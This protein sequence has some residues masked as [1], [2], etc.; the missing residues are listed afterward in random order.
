MKRSIQ[1]ELMDDEGLD[2]PQ[3][4]AEN[5]SDIARYNTLTSANAL[6]LRLVRQLAPSQRMKALDIGIGSGDFVAYAAPRLSSHWVGLDLS[7]RILSIARAIRGD[8]LR[9]CAN[10]DATRLPFADGAFDV[11]TC[12]LTVHHLQP[13]QVVALFRECA[14]VCQR[15]FAMVDF[16]RNYAGLV[17]AWLLTRLTS[18]NRFTRNDGVQSIRRAYTVDEVRD[19]LSEAG[20]RNAEV[21]SQT[22][23]RYSILW[24]R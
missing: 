20:L 2:D 19:L 8:L 23:L 9:D 1:A 12:A 15:G 14:R 10:A 4:L 16:Q 24:R 13:A 5:L 7:P 18:R 3:G 21:R 6:M 17:G 11:V 22:P